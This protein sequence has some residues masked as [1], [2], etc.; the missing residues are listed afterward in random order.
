MSLTYQVVNYVILHQ[1]V[2]LVKT[3]IILILQIINVSTVLITFQVVYIVLLT[4]NV[5]NVKLPIISILTIHANYVNLLYKDAFIATLHL[6]VSNAEL[7][8]ISTLPTINVTNVHNQAVMYVYKQIPTVVY[9]VV[10]SFI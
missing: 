5:L 2:L 10:M 3:V 4:P 6:S 8:S 1:F 9:L 7:D